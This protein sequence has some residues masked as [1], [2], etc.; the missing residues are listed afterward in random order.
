MNF[1][2]GGSLLSRLGV[3]LRAKS[4]KN[5]ARPVGWGRARRGGGGGKGGEFPPLEANRSD[6]DQASRRLKLERLARHIHMEGAPCKFYVGMIWS[7]NRYPLFG[8]MPARPRSGCL[9]VRRTGP[10][11]E[12]D[13]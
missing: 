5:R 8:I 2:A 13:D 10:P 7:E 6:A 12:R 11:V 4:K 9:L 1:T 3:R